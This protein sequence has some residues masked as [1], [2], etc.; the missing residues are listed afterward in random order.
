MAMGLPCSSTSSL[1]VI[2]GL[3]QW[4]AVFGPPEQIQLD[5]PAAHQSA[6]L[7]KFLTIYGIKKNLG[8]PYQARCQGQ[9]ERLIRDLKTQIRLG[10]AKKDKR[11]LS[12]P[13]WLSVQ[14]G[15][16]L[17][18]HSGDRVFGI[19]PSDM[20]LGSFSDP[21]SKI[22]DSYLLLQ[23]ARNEKAFLDEL[24]SATAAPIRDPYLPD[25]QVKLSRI[26]NGRRVVQ[27]PL[28]IE[29]KHP[30]NPYLYKLVG[31]QGWVSLADLLPYYNSTAA[32]A[33][34]DATEPHRAY[35]GSIGLDQLPE[36]H[37]VDLENVHKGDFLLVAKDNS[38]GSMR[39]IYVTEFVRRVG[40]NIEV[41]G[42]SKNSNGQ[43][44]RPPAKE[45]SAYLWTPSASAIIGAFRPTPT[46]RLP[47]QVLQWMKSHGI[48]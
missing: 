37:R 28:T 7:D 44:K 6:N 41:L 10:A 27:G 38:K 36:N 19:S 9:V 1:H 39:T 34:D 16:Y 4:I 8:V 29:C 25:Q 45:Q 30:T 35:I 17:H 40:K 15:I 42:L 23:S 48:A 13:W 24:T 46:R 31:H 12:L 20:A 11:G 33:I 22:A 26:I 21:T 43:W 18:S 14:V 2:L 32:E 47:R 5:S 3:M